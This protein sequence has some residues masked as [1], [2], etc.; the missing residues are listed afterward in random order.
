MTQSFL[1]L[2]ARVLFLALVISAT[3]LPGRA[4]TKPPS[5]SE[6]ATFTNPL[7]PSGPDPW[8]IY[9][10]GFYYYM[11]TTARNLTIWRTAD[12]TEL[13]RA[14]KR[15]VWTPP[16]AGPDSHEI[17]A[18][19]LHFLDG[20][21]YIYFGAD[22]GT[23]QTHRMFVLENPSPNP[24]EG[25]FTYQSER[26]TDTWAIDPSVFE[27]RGQLYIVWS[28]WPGTQNGTQNIYLSKLKN[29]WTMEGPRVLLSTP[30]YSWETIGDLPKETPPHVNVNE[31]PEILKH[32]GK[33]FLIYS[34]SGC[35]T[36]YYA[37]GMLE[38]SADADLMNPAAWKKHPQAVFSESPSAHAFGPGHNAFFK[39][40]DGTQDW[41]IYH[42]NPET[43]QGCGGRRSPRAQ[44]FT[45]NP[46]GT[47][48]FGSPMPI[49]KPLPKPSGTK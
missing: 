46:D 6:A 3:A 5:G 30:T 12:I 31:G 43:H 41:I 18:P 10:E 38:A 32:N 44:P 8:V 49:D 2:Q 28:G 35:W 40:P 48:N 25:Q 22:Y 14:E 1:M 37:L 17:W 29:P 13:K 33:I 42:A 15:V 19:E 21:W 7:L 36:D 47:P 45:W 16:D 27:N 4:Q 34:A 20:K 9:H 26:A 24:L 39:S 11:N 23:N